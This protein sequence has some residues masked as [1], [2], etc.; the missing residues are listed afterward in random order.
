MI[1][2]TNNTD[3]PVTRAAVEFQPGETKFKDD[4]LSPGKL[5]QI[6]A[7]PALKWVEVEDRP[8]DKPDKKP[9]AQEKE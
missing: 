6:S 5:A 4:Q 7:H 1:I 2:V 8:T 9:N 3:K